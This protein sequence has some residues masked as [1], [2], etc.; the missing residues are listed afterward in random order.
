MGHGFS[1]QITEKCGT[2]YGNKNYISGHPKW[3]RELYFGTE[4]VVANKIS[5]FSPYTSD[6]FFLH[7]IP[8]QV[9]KFTI[10]PSLFIKYTHLPVMTNIVNVR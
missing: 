3:K 9:S 7:Y 5:G 8:F 1:R 10:Y 2:K 4:G 6:N